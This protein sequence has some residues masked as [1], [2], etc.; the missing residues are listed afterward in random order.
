MRRHAGFALLLMSGSAAA[1]N[2]L[3][4][5]GVGAE[6]QG[7]GG[8]DVAAVNDTAALVVNP[9]RLAAIAGHRLDLFLEPSYYIGNRHRDALGNDVEPDNKLAMLF[10][11]GYAQRLGDSDVSA[12]VGLFFQGGAGLVYKD[13][14]TAFGT[15]DRLSSLLGSLRLVPGLGWKIDEHWSLGLSLGLSYSVAR[16]QFFPHTSVNAADSQFAGFRIDGAHGFSFG[17]RVGLQ[18]DPNPQWSFAVAYAPPTPIRLENGRMHVNE[19]AFGGGTV[20]YRSVTIDGLAFASDLSIGMAWEP[21]PPW[22]FAAKLGWLDWSRSM[23]SSTIRATDPDDP[24]VPATLQLGSPLNWRDQYVVALG[25]SWQ[26]TPATRLRAGINRAR[27]PSDARYLTPTLAMIATTAIT[28]GVSH[29]LGESWEFDVAAQ[30]HP[31]RTVRYMNADGPLGADASERWEA[32][33]V[34]V[35]LSRV[36]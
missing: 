10:G 5:I 22:R 3:Y 27:D 16:Q 1:G 21:L 19:D 17:G 14:Q 34:V 32:C 28:A 36:W 24:D 6:S 18:Y 33:A 2:G 20:K 30:Y 25:A 11:A 4:D 29:R 26:W 9:A 7:L 31:A 12:G 23:H 35:Q 8:A 13:L 15:E